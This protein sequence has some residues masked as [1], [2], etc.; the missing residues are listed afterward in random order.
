MDIEE[1]TKILEENK[2]LKKGIKKLMLKRRKWKER[3]Y[4]IK[5]KKKV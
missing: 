3:Y 4:K 5:E 2:A 1:T